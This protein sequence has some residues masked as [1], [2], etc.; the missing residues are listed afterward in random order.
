MRNNVKHIAIRLVL[1][2]TSQQQKLVDK[3]IVFRGVHALSLFR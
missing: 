1:I 2:E 3:L